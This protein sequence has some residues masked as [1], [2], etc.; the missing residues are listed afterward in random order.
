MSKLERLVEAHYVTVQLSGTFRDRM[1]ARLDA[2]KASATTTAGKLRAQLGKQLVT[3]DAQEDRYL[4][5]VGDPDWPKEKLSVKMR[6]IREERARIQER[7]TQADSPIDSGYEVLTTVLNLLTDPQALYQA[8]SLRARKIINKAIFG[9]LFVQ[10]DEQGPYV[11]RDELNEPFETVIYARRS[12]SLSEALEQ[13]GARLMAGSEQP[14]ALGDLLVA[15][16]GSPCSSKNRMVEIVTHYSNTPNLLS[17]LRRTICAVTTMVTRDDEPDIA[18]SA[19]ADRAW[20]VKERLSP[21]DLDQLVESFK[22]GTTILEL[23][24]RYGISR[25]TIRTILRQHRVRRLP[26]RDPLS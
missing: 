21:R 5:L 13:A 22:E 19:P 23:V 25:T 20:R 1:Q 12:S 7:L 8:S 24:D 14:Q 15:A 2:T 9:K 26:K 10:A 3:L 17:D 4:D 11:A 16:L 18:A 6:G